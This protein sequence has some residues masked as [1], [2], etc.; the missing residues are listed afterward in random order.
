MYI[1]DIGFFVHWVLIFIT[2][3]SLF[4]IE[5]I[6]FSLF[7]YNCLFPSLLLLLLRLQTA[8]N[9]KKK[10]CK[11]LAQHS[12]CGWHHTSNALW[13]ELENSPFNKRKNQEV[14]LTFV[15]MFLISS[16]FLKQITQCTFDHSY[17]KYVLSGITS[18]SSHV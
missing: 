10:C 17:F 13:R 16:S 18:V 12:N 1:L 2:D 7:S 9:G 3:F 6:Y 5:T 11:C 4:T 15:I 8:R 14:L